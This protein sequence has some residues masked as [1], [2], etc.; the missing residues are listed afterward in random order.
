MSLVVRKKGRKSKQVVVPQR[1]LTKAV[2]KTIYRNTE[3][4][5]FFDVYVP[6]NSL[7]STWVSYS[8]SNISQGDSQVTRW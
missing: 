4:K 2:N 5:V 1:A 7:T 6:P 8:M 3:L